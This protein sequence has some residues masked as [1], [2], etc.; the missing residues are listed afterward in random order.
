MQARITSHL[1]TLRASAARLEQR[2]WEWG[3]D[4]L[5]LSLDEVIAVSHDIGVLKWTIKDLEA[6]VATAVLQPA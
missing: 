2:L 4:G 5:G 3:R 1:E 6:R